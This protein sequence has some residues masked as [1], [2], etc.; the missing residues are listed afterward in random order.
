MG[1]MVSQ[2]RAGG[3]SWD[4]SLDE[5]PTSTPTQSE[6]SGQGQWPQRARFL[7]G[8]GTQDDIIDLHLAPQPFIYD[9]KN[10]ERV[11]ELG[12]DELGRRATVLCLSSC[13]Q[14][15]WGWSSHCIL[16]LHGYLR[17]GKL[18]W[19]PRQGDPGLLEHSCL[20]LLSQ[21]PLPPS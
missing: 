3:G 17:V 14:R 13:P 16:G 5:G 2:T 1:P 11:L 19:G 20:L 6:S 7:G 18:S 4:W 21:Q 8:R 10:R 9:A 12:E 15:A